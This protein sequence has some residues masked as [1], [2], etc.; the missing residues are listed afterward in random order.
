MVKVRI[1]K[2][3]KYAYKRPEGG[4]WYTYVDYR[5]MIEFPA[6][7]TPQILDF[8]DVEVEVKRQGDEIIIRPRD[9]RNLRRELLG[10]PVKDALKSIVDAQ[11][12]RG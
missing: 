2:H 5:L 11:K 10:K 6:E 4:W 3:H 12:V 8:A 7:F 9:P 1:I